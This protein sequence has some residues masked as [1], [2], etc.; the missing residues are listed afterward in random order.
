MRI[1]LCI[2]EGEITFQHSGTAFS[3]KQVAHLI[4]KGST[5]YLEDGPIGRF[6]TG[7]LSTHII[8]K[9]PKVSG[10][11]TDGRGF[12]FVLDRTGN[13]PKELSDSMYRSS[14]EF[15]RSVQDG[16][17]D[18]TLTDYST[19]YDYALTA[20][21]G[22]IAQQGVESLETYAPYVLAF[23]HEIGSIDIVREGQRR[24]YQRQP[25][26]PLDRK[27]AKATR[28][29]AKV[30]PVDIHSSSG[31]QCASFL[32]AELTEDAV[33]VA[34]AAKR[35]G[36]GYEVQFG[37]EVPR[38]FMAFPL[39]GTEGI[40]FP[41]VINSR[42]FRPQKDRDGLY[43][44]PDI[45]DDNKANKRLIETACPLSLTLLAECAKAKWK[46]IHLL[47]NLRATAPR[48]V[49]EKWL[50]PLIKT[51]LVEPIR[52]QPLV[53][54]CGGELIAACD[55]WIPIGSPTAPAEALWE[56]CQKDKESNDILVDQATASS[57]ESNVRA[58]A[59]VLGILPEQM[60]ESYTFK[61]CSEQLDEFG[62]LDRLCE[63]LRAGSDPLA[64]CNKLFGLLIRAGQTPLFDTLSLL[65]DQGGTFQKR[66]A[67]RLDC[68]INDELK[69]IG[70]RL[71]LS[72]RSGLLHRDVTSTDIHKLLQVKT[73]KHVLIEITNQLRAEAARQRPVAGFRQGNTQLFGWL[74]K[75]N[76]IEYLESFPAI[77]Q[78]P[79]AEGEAL[80]RMARG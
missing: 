12:T 8:S 59:S 75:N 20:D 69:D 6:G 63:E 18:S 33:T 19:R 57:W 72:I 50:F 42:S 79:Q 26:K 35:I 3:M 43:L 15:V 45:T 64:W 44:G 73:Q 36:E 68:E 54:S 34:V 58:W 70:K 7:F 30:T 37:P 24:R 41:G 39:F 65:P 55:A 66:N 17:E 53:L 2:N 11:L 38:L 49:D 4:H 76:A 40:G 28:G 27:R 1:R 29:M 31:E 61:D 46:G 25:S 23:N 60:P 80:N 52:S 47:C 56:L 78:E 67:L 62:S 21:V 14:K 74:L 10:R 13:T 16:F 9:A 51:S 71:G 48:G 32:V 5:K 22:H 77:T